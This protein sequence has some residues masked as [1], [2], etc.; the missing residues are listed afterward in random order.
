MVLSLLKTTEAIA[1]DPCDEPNLQ[2]GVDSGVF[3]WQDCANNSQRWKVRVLSRN[4]RGVESS[5]A[6]IISANAPISVEAFELESHDTLDISNPLENNFAMRLWGNNNDGVDIVMAAN[7]RICLDVSGDNNGSVFVGRTRTQVD[8][9]F[10]L[11]SGGICGVETLP[12]EVACGEPNI[13]PSTESGPWL[14]R[15]CS[16]PESTWKLRMAGGGGFTQLAGSVKSDI[17]FESISGFSVDPRNDIYEE[18]SDKLVGFD[19]RTYNQSTDGVNITP[20]AGSETCLDIYGIDPAQLKLGE[21][22]VGALELPLNIETLKPCRAEPKRDAPSFLVILTDDQRFDTTWVMKQVE[23]KLFSRSIK[24]ENA[25]ITS[26]LCCPA[27]ASILSGG[28]YPFNTGITQVIGDNGGALSFR[29]IQDRDT[30]ATTLQAEG[31]K[32]AYTGGKYLNDYRPP[33]IPP[34]WDLFINNNTGPSAGDWFDFD[35]TEGSAGTTS[36]RGVKRR[37]SQYVTNYHRDRLLNFLDDLNDDEPFL[38]FYSVFAPHKATIPHPRDTVPGIVI[39]GIDLDSYVYQG[40]AFNETDLSDKP[41]WVADPTKFLSA[42]NTGTGDD[43]EFHRDQLRTLLSVDRAIGQLVD[44]I[45]SLGRLDNTVIV[46]LSDNGFMWGEHSVH[47]KGMAYEESV[48]VPFSIY[49]PNTSART[50]SAI[51]SAN[52]DLGATIFDLAGV[53]KPSEGLSLLPLINGNASTWRTGL[54]MQGWGPHEGANGTWSALRTQQWKYIENA[55]GEVELYDMINDQ[56]EMES[57]HD[58]PIFR[59]TL[60]ELARQTAEHRGLAPIVFR[61]PKARINRAY[62]FLLKAWGGTEPYTWDVSE[63]ALPDGLTLNSATGLISGTPTATG[64]FK[65][66]VLITDSSV[67]PKSGEPQSFFAPGKNVN[68]FYTLIVE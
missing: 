8:G 66:K 61:T 45:E 14:W 7:Q 54:Q 65:F 13:D 10:N 46:F 44:K 20:A 24:F 11:S 27:R 25:F 23:Q 37:V 53:D 41:N 4:P 56:Y 60:D 49:L 21:N 67:R 2:K 42:K 48:R 55:K 16:T 36:G 40:R 1:Y 57:Q 68:N 28:F 19:Y 43:E 22:K 33:Y 35:V 18:I 34:G 47:Q 9:P 15:D 5:F 64:N 39:D 52:L 3:V 38:A 62:N 26:P 63:G 32:T 58:N 29:G 12:P 59:T 50:E 31:Y 51:V 30:I 6:G 17:E